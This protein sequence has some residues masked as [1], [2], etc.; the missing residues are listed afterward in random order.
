M[1]GSIALK[2]LEKD[3]R[4]GSLIEARNYLKSL[5]GTGQIECTW[6]DRLGPVGLVTL[7]LCPATMS[8]AEAGWREKVAGMLGRR[9][10][11]R[12]GDKAALGDLWPKLTDWPSWCAEDL[13]DE[14]YGLRAKLEADKDSGAAPSYLVSAS[15]RLASSKLLSLLPKAALQAFGFKAELLPD[16]PPYVVV[17][18]PTNPKVVV[19]VENPVAFERAVAATADLPVAWVSTY[20]FGITNLDGVGARMAA[21][22]TA[23]VSPIPLV[24]AGSPPP[25]AELL[26]HPRLLHW[27]DLDLTGLL[28]FHSMRSAWPQLRLSA[29]Y[30]PM[31]TLLQ[32]GGGHPYA[33]ATGKPRQERW[34]SEDP[35]IASLLGLCAERAVDQEHLS[36]EVIRMLALQALDEVASL[37]HMRAAGVAVTERV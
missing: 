31:A 17:A 27:G 6:V 7:K 35:T 33:E 25:L 29:L 30:W 11:V 16:S 4:I 32:S 5:R 15:G 2:R 14:L 22:V 26:G 10:D 34:T 20:G 3:P 8:S 28:I 19:L 24:R 36:T 21:T 1:Q 18:G 23:L 37:A 12:E 13:I 9:E